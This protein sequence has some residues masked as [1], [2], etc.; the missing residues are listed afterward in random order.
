MEGAVRPVEAGGSSSSAGAAVAEETETV[1]GV[2]YGIEGVWGR[3]GFFVV[4]VQLSLF[5]GVNAENKRFSVLS[6]IEC[7]AER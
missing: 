4:V 5:N 2:G 1:I 7:E 6:W 3:L